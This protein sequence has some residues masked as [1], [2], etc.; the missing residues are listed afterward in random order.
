MLIK[1]LTLYVYAHLAY[2]N[3]SKEA[4]VAYDETK[5]YRD[6]NNKHIVVCSLFEIANNHFEGW[7]PWK[8]IDGVI[9]C[10][11]NKDTT[12]F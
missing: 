10:K 1:P 7:K 4:N 5:Q 12:I 3:V 11:L 9:F 2:I 8:E 6:Q